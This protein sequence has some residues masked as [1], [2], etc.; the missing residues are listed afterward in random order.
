[1]ETIMKTKV[2]AGNRL[3]IWEIALLLGV[4]V[5]L[6]S[7]ARALHTQD[8]LADKVVRLHVLANSDSEE[9]QAL[10][11]QV[12]DA[13]LDRAEDLLAQ[14]SS[15]AEAEGKLRG[16]LLEFERLAEAV[17]REAGYDYEVTAEL[18]DTEFPTRE[19]EDFTL[20]AGE[21]LALRIL[22]GDAAGRNWWCVVFPPL[23]TAASA[24]VPASALAAGFTA[25]EVRLITEEDRG[26]VLKFKA[27]EFWETLREK[28][29]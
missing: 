14:P 27:V 6:L 10:K 19:Y 5:C 15:R 26:Y 16:Q 2:K 7:G 4:A 20:P 17:V 23:C 1:M 25:D 21:Y 28:W 29:N 12:R 22:I 24:D 18:T 3:K 8:E 11:L 9:D 13:V